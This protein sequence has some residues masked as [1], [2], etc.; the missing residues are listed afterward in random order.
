MKKIMIGISLIALLLLGACSASG[1]K[2]K[3]VSEKNEDTGETKKQSGA[4]KLGE[5]IVVDGLEITIKQLKTTTVVKNEG[6]DKK[7]LYG[8]EITGKNIGSIP[9][10]LGAIDFIVTTADGKEHKIDDSVTNFGDEI[11]Q[12]KSLTGKAYFVI[13][14]DQKIAQL[15]YKPSDKVLANWDLK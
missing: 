12:D 4:S 6:K 13:E 5:T 9:M 11:V 7:D 3:K 14:K 2:E 10:G 8:V 1:T 15:Q